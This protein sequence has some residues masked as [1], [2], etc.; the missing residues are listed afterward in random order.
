MF[1]NSRQD[2]QARGVV[3]RGATEQ[4]LSSIA[5][6]CALNTDVFVFLRGLCVNHLFNAPAARM[7]ARMQIPLISPVFFSATLVVWPFICNSVVSHVRLI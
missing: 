6:F 4:P 2:T 5:S 3:G 1:N 7:I